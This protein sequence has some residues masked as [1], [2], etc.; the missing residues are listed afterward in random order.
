MYSTLHP[1]VLMADATAMLRLEGYLPGEIPGYWLADYKFVE[2]VMRMGEGATASTYWSTDF[3]FYTAPDDRVHSPFA[4]AHKAVQGMGYRAAT[5]QQWGLMLGAMFDVVHRGF[6]PND[7][8]VSGYDPFAKNSARM[9]DGRTFQNSD[10]LF[11][12]VTVGQFSRDMRQRQA[13]NLSCTAHKW[14]EAPP[15]IDGTVIL[16]CTKCDTLW[17]PNWRNQNWGENRTVVGAGLGGRG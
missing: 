10:A 15:T 1:S 16:R 8:K 9:R 12:F 5:W 11:H 7:I 6:D 3:T 4:P 2:R 17:R 13:V 14:R